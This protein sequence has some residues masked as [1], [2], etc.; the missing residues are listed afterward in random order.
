MRIR[1]GDW[2]IH[3]ADDGQYK[4]VCVLVGLE[5][6]SSSGVWSLVNVLEPTSADARIHSWFTSE[7]SC[8]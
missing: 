3:Y 4:S 8:I 2:I 1:V 7:K 6:C 5:N